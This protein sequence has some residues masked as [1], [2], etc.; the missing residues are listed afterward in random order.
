MSDT[1]SCTCH[2]DEAPKPCQKR[3]AL[4]ECQAARIERLEAALRDIAGMDYFYVCENPEEPMIK[5]RAA[6]EDKP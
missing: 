5:A 3:Y 4:N 2:P 6:L 1:R